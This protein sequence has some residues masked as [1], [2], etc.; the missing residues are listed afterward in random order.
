MRYDF[1][2][3]ETVDLHDNDENNEEY[4]TRINFFFFFED[5]L[6]I[7]LLKHISLIQMLI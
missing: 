6:K 4:I 1:E 2:D 5:Y 7:M 3:T